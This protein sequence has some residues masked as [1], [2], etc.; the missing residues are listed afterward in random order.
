MNP[1]ASPVDDERKSVPSGGIPPV[2]FKEVARK[3]SVG[4]TTFAFAK[5]GYVSFRPRGFNEPK[6]PHSFFWGI[7]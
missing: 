5:G 2:L 6:A 7:C 3:D 4:A 1:P